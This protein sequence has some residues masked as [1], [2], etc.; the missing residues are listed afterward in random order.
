MS[1]PATDIDPRVTFNYAVE[2]DGLDV[3]YVQGVNIPEVE[4]ASVENNGA[5]AVHSTKTGGRLKF[6]DITLDKSMP[7]GSSDKW[8]WLWLTSVR[9]PVS[10]VGRAASAY[11]RNISI[12]HYG[13]GREII[14]RWDCKGVWPKKIAPSKNDS[15]QEGEKMMESITLS[16]D[17]YSRL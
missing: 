17:S 4:V 16:C 1:I 11:K 5:G 15:T 7:A 9:D 14:D 13:P 8:A 3:A 2:I 10:G 12:I 6:G